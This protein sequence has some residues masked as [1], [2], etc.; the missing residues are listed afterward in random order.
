MYQ[1]IKIEDYWIIYSDQ[2][3]SIG[4]YYMGQGF[5]G[6]NMFQWHESQANQFTDEY[7]KVIACSKELNGL[8][9]FVPEWENGD[10]EWESKIGYLAIEDS[11]NAGKLNSSWHTPAWTIAFTSGF[12]Q[13]YNK[14]KE[15]YRFTEEDMRKCWDAGYRNVVARIN[16][17][18]P[19]GQF[20]QYL[21]KPK[22]YTVEIENVS[23]KEVKVISWKEM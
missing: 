19:F 20:I 1:A 16:D 14:A 21:T 11:I 6:T 15:K 7:G 5:A 10:K 8:P 3:R 17:S 22:Q 23:D 9:V 4:D 18:I 13:G 12:E 2:K